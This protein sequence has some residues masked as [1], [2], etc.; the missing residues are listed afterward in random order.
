[1]SILPIGLGNSYQ[2]RELSVEEFGALYAA[3][4]EAYFSASLIV[5]VTS[6]LSTDEVALYEARRLAYPAVWRMQWALEHEGV[7]VGWTYAYQQDHETLY[8]CNTAI[9]QDHR[10]KGL[11][12]IILQHVL[13]VAKTQG[14]Q[15]VTSKHYAS[16]NAIII[17]KLKAGFIITGLALDEKYGLMVHLT[18]YLHPQR[19]KVAVNRIGETR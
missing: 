16:N 2:L 19:E 10:G 18:K 6:H 7:V 13:S 11:Y 14:F 3:R 12:S 15:I 9:A 4:Q 8:M 5:D 1:M 17:P